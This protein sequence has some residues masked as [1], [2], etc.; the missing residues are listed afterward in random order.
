[1][2]CFLKFLIKY[3]QIYFKFVTGSSEILGRT[4]IGNSP[5]VRTEE[6]IFFEEIFRAKNA[7]AQW[8]ALQEPANNLATVKT[9][10]TKN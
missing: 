6:K 3:K 5:E 8:V 4:L 1:L 7:T 9:T 2:D 10:N